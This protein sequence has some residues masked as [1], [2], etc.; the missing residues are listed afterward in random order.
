MLSTY[1][2]GGVPSGGGGGGGGGAPERF[3]GF[4]KKPLKPARSKPAAAAAAAKAPP[5]PCE[6]STTTLHAEFKALPSA[7]KAPR[8]YAAGDDVFMLNGDGSDAEEDPWDFLFGE[9]TDKVPELE[10]DEV[11]SFEVEDDE[12]SKDEFSDVSQSFED[13]KFVVKRRPP[14]QGTGVMYSGPQLVAV[15]DSGI[16]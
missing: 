14:K 12:S 6:A 11:E 4:K 9:Q 8:P 1:F 16:D 13:R 2:G 3:S 10:E 5:E 7:G 15:D